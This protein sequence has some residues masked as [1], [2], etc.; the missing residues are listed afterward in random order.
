MLTLENK[1]LLRIRSLSENLWHQAVEGTLRSDRPKLELSLQFLERLTE[2]QYGHA[3]AETVRERRFFIAD[4]V[5]INREDY[6]SRIGYSNDEENQGLRFLR[7]SWANGAW[8]LGVDLYHLAGYHRLHQVTI[9][10]YNQQ[11]MFLYPKEFVGRIV[12]A[13]TLPTDIEFRKAA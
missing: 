10:H 5:S 12:P 9:G 7:A 3:F 13:H 2:Q 4:I 11:V 8:T 6:H 1:D